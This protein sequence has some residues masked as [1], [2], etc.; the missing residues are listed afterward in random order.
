MSDGRTADKPLSGIRVLE[1]GQ[2]IAGPFA[3]SILAYF[4]AEL[5]KIE[6]PGKGDPLRSWRQLD[7]KGTS[8]WWRSIGRNK[9]SVTLNLH[10][11][12]GREIARRLIDS[13]D[14]LIE[15]FRPGTMEKWGLGPAVF[16][17][18][19]PQL[20]YTRVSG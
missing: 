8:Y 19:N 13:S 15:N 20:V 11:E 10:E 16:K 2:L 9:K 7:E 5:I 3:G 18:S 12:E 14:V 4:G 17:Q 6:P 1:M